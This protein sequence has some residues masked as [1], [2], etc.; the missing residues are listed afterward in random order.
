MMSECR[1]IEPLLYLYREGELTDHERSE[2]IAHARTCSRCQGILAELQSLEEALTPVRESAPDFPAHAQL[3]DR[4]LDR[5]SPRRAGR[6]VKT[7]RMPPGEDLMGW[8]RPALSVA[9]LAAVIVLVSQQTRDAYMIAKLENRLTARGNAAAEEPSL[10]HGVRSMLAGTIQEEQAHSF[11]SPVPNTALAEDP[12]QLLGRGLMKLLG[13]KNGLLEELSRRY[14]E[15][16]TVTLDDGID[17]RERKI[18]DTE[19]RAF[20]KEFEQ[21]IRQ[22]AK[23]P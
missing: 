7:W 5:I 17:E 19:G 23:Q 20:L 16:S 14:P 10:I 13:H 4:V 12:V 1:R 3:T 21:L 22:G 9:V 6:T 15:L 18:L 11:F 8:L 2:V